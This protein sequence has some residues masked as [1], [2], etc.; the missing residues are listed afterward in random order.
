MLSNWN[1]CLGRI[2]SNG[3]GRGW[4]GSTPGSS[5][6][7]SIHWCVIHAIHI[8]FYFIFHRSIAATAPGTTPI[9]MD[10]IRLSVVAKEWSAAGTT[11]APKTDA[12]NILFRITVQR[13]SLWYP[14]LCDVNITMV[15]RWTSISVY[16]I[17]GRNTIIVLRCDAN[18]CLE[19]V[20]CLSAIPSLS[21]RTPSFQDTQVCI[22]VYCVWNRACASM[23]V[24]C[25][26]WVVYNICIWMTC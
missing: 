21:L 5:N 12:I 17:V 4:R 9:L 2:R 18:K 14:R 15:V 22:D 23:L 10:S 3:W 1:T 13:H 16:D 19:S 20:S 6:G 7:I 26:V 11:A 25:R 8:I 24:V